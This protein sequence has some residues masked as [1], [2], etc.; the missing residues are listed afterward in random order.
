MNEFTEQNFLQGMK[1]AV[2]MG[3]WSSEREISIIS[4]K[5]VGDALKE[6]GFEPLILDLKSE[7]DADK[8]IKNIDIAFIALHGKGGEDGFI[9]DLLKRRG[10]KFTGSDAQACR[11]SINKAETKKFGETF[12]YRHQIL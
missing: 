5:A 12:L 4:G 3:G 2:L 8:R 11:I 1:I 7:E 9:Q 10:I 6:V